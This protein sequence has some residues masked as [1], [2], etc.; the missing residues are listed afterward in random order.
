MDPVTLESRKNGDRYHDFCIDDAIFHIKKAQEA[1]EEGLA[2]PE[3]WY[4]S[5]KFTAKVLAKSLPFILAVQMQES[6]GEDQGS[7][8]GES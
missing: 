5:S 8:S 1:L 2:D 7:S 3:A 6:Q 4:T